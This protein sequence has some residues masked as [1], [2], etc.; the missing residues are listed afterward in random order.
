MS[1][2]NRAALVAAALFAAA[3]FQARAD[4]YTE[5]INKKLTFR[6]GKV[7][8]EHRFGKIEVRTHGGSS[9][10]VKAT[11]R[12]SDSSIGRAISVTATEGAGGISIVTHY[13]D[14]QHWSNRNGNMSYSVDY[15]I[16]MPA[17]APL[18][19]RN[20]FGNVEV[21]G[22][23]AAGDITNAM[24]S[25]T[26]R[27][28]GGR[29]EIENSFGAVEVLDSD[30]DLVIRNQNGAVTIENVKGSVNGAA[31]TRTSSCIAPCW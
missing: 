15:E 24:G 6:G 21:D 18:T 10:D 30:G 11:V 19:V 5:V 22:L 17:N 26:I 12:A 8:I 31:R 14:T 29:Q 25:V 1:R 4:D 13:P 20:R 27:N 7:S 16:E 3:A 9:V 28:S 2:I 23:R